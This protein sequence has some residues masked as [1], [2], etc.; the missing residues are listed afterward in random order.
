LPNVVVVGLGLHR[1]SGTLR[2]ATHGRSVWDLNISSLLPAPAVTAVNPTSVTAATAAANITVTGS[3]FQ[4]SASVIWNGSAV[5][6]TFVNSGSLTAV[7]P[8]TDL[9]NGGTA[10]VAVMNGT[11]GKLSNSVSVT[12]NNPIATEASLSTSSVSAGS[13]AIAETI[14]GTGFVT[15]SK[16]TWKGA[17]LTTTYTSG[18]AL[19]ATIPATDLAAAGT[20]SVRVVNP[21]PG[22]GTSVPLTFTVNDGAP[23]ATSLAPNVVDAGASSFLMTVTGTYFY[24]SSKITWKGA[25]LPTT[26]VNATT[27]TTTVPASDVAA[28]GTV[29]VRVVTPA[30]GG[31]T[32]VPVTF[33]IGDAAPV[34]TS[35]SP[36]S[37]TA[38]GAAFQLTVTGSHFYPL[39]KVTW[40]GA[41]L[42]T[43]YVNST[44]LHATVPT[45]DIAAHGTV[46]VRVVNPAPG[47]G[48]SV[49]VTFT[50]NP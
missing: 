20:V 41:A 46:S 29:S 13:A 8:V 7:V 48:T 10:A 2:A 25:N 42:A 39:S 14:T 18:T 15:S 50:I 43:T 49:P 9:T 35:I 21:A 27:L 40:K 24:P 44:T 4:A 6:T 36:T 23:V 31:G 16:V 33:T 19:K 5:P 45:T 22:G 11:A 47:G 38:G 26:Y 12:V 3:L 37:A 34:A 30:P 28:T 32:S 17:A 1:A